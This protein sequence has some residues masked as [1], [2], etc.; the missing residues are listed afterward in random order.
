MLTTQAP[1]AAPSQTTTPATPAAPVITGTTAASAAPAATT[2]P[3]ATA[4]S[5]VPA[6][7]TP[8]A[9]AAP[10]EQPTNLVS[11]A[12][13]VLAIP[14]KFKVV[15]QDGTIDHEATLA[16]TLGSYTHL[17]KRFGSGDIPPEN[18]TGY[19]LDYSAFPEGVKMN[20]EGE[21]ALLKSLH[22][23]GMT[24]KQVQTVINKY[25]EVIKQGLELQKTQE[26]ERVKTT[27][28]EVATEL[29]TAWGENNDTNIKAA[30]RGFNHLADEADK[31]EIAKIGV[32][33]KVTYKLFMKFLS[34]V[35]AGITE[36]TQ[37]LNAQG[38]AHS[39]TRDELMRSDAYLDENH[40]DHA[41]TVAKVTAIYKQMYPKK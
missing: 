13:S 23:S 3:A 9:S 12:A 15:R 18:E 30:V 25:G 40:K 26:A 2:T 35:G 19:K 38:A 10:T 5:A 34:K 8:A 4:A 21:K 20:P 31:A 14:E 29:A 22:A 7:A 39:N 37:V 32:D 11:A 17:E 6:S 33:G 27:L 1:E 28:T 36:D 24:N 41:S 16:K